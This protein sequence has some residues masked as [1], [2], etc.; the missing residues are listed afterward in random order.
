MSGVE[1]AKQYLPPYLAD[2]SHSP[3]ML[4]AQMDYVGIDRA[5]LHASPIMGMLNGY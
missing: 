5:V 1:Y 2:L 4:V 3:E